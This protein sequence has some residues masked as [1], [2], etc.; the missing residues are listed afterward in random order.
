MGGEKMK[1]RNILSLFVL[2]LFVGCSDDITTTPDSLCDYSSQNLILNESKLETDID[3]EQDLTPAEIEGLVFMREE[4]KLARDVYIIFNNKY[5]RKIFDIIARS[6]Q[7]H[8]DTM[9]FLLTRHGIKDPVGNNPIGVFENEDL[10]TLYEMLIEEGS[11]SLESA[12]YVGCLIEEIDI[13]DIDEL[14]E[15]AISRDILLAYSHL[16]NG[17]KNHMR[18]YVKSWELQTGQDYKPRF[19]STDLFDKIMNDS[20]HGGHGGHGGCG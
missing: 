20:S 3:S 19:I 2:T 15:A 9:L 12:L 8:T 16:M 14:M 1:H 10:Q 11:L 17:S 5:D 13:L 4:E 18:A 6:E 7:G